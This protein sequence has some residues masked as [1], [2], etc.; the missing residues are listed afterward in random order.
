MKKLFALFVCLLV[1][2]GCSQQKDVPA[3]PTPNAKDLPLVQVEKETFSKETYDSFPSIKNIVYYLKIDAK[4]VQI[5][6]QTD[7]KLVFCFYQ[8]DVD[9]HDET[10]LSTYHYVKTM[11]KDGYK[12]SQLDGAAIST[13]ILEKEK[14]KMSLRHI[15]SEWL[16]ERN[17]ESDYYHNIIN[18]NVICEIESE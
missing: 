7:K 12:V 14:I 8:E 4:D 1:I 5:I 10:I 15:Q 13:F 3:D 11:E 9:V 16:E 6:E 2:V 17:K 18:E